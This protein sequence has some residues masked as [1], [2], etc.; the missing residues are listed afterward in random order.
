VLA[1]TLARRPP[2]GFPQPGPPTRTPHSPHSHSN[3]AH[4]TSKIRKIHPCVSME[5]NRLFS[6]ALD[7]S[8][9]GQVTRVEHLK[10]KWKLGVLGQAQFNY[11]FLP[12][13]DAPDSHQHAS[14]PVAAAPQP[15]S[16]QWLVHALQGRRHQQCH[17][18]AW[19][20]NVAARIWAHRLTRCA[21]LCAWQNQNT[22][23]P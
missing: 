8:F 6:P 20:R 3:N 11:L 10:L 12:E 15:S 13:A 4:S 7:H 17:S 5:V 16:P 18:I 1:Y 14:L 2:V 9:G 23:F 19:V 21:F 22:L